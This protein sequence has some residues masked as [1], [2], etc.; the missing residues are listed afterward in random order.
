MR[1]VEGV[2]YLTH[3]KTEILDQLCTSDH[4]S[5]GRVQRGAEGSC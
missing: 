4:A 3:I 1:T 5:A 2:V